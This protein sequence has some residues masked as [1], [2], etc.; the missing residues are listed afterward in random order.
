MNLLERLKDSPVSIVAFITGVL[1]LLKVF[2][3]V[4]GI[5]GELLSLIEKFSLVGVGGVFGIIYMDWKKRSHD[6]HC[7]GYI[8]KE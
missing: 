6:K 1:T 4:I 7:Q 3:P 5:K 2:G 8:E